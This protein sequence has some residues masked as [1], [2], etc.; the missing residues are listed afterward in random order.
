MNVF[1]LENYFKRSY[2]TI[3]KQIYKMNKHT[4]DKYKYYKNGQMMISKLGIEWL[5]KNSFKQ[6]YLKLLEE[7]KMKLTEEY[8]K[9]GFPYDIF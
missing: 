4:N 3:R 7:Y 6:K 8:I 9:K 1:E 5:C 2:E